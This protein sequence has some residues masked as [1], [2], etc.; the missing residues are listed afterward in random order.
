MYEKKGGVVRGQK[1]AKKMVKIPF[2][3]LLTLRAAAPAAKMD[4]KI[5][6]PA[7][8]FPEACCVLCV[9]YKVSNPCSWTRFNWLPVVPA[10]QLSF[11]HDY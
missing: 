2:F 8:M 6:T 3:G 7:Y 4:L 11:Y 9:H 1:N 10:M 5:Y